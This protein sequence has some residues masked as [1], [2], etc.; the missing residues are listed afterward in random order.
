MRVRYIGCLVL[1]VFWAACTD[2]TPTALKSAPA[3]ARHTIDPTGSPIQIYGSWHCGSDFCTWSTVRS[4]TEFDAKNHW[5]IDR[6]D[7]RPS[8][9]L[10]V[11]S[12]VLPGV[13]PLGLVDTKV[14]AL[15]DDWSGLKVVWRRERR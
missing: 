9:N 15:D 3:S 8:V 14:A 12:F 1:A 7:G 6:G 10:V 11:L 5:L 13:L 2:V 4:Q